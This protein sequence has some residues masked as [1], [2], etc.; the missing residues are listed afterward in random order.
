VLIVGLMIGAAAGYLVWGRHPAGARQAS[1]PGTTS[2]EV[3]RPPAEPVEAPKPYSDQAVTPPTAQPGA[4][5]QQPPAPAPREPAVRETPRPAVP[6]TGRIVV[7]SV[8]SRAGVLINGQWKGRTPLTLSAVKFGKYVVRVSQPGYMA[9]EQSFSLG[10]NDPDRT[11][12]VRLERA[13]PPPAAKPRPTPPTPPS[14]GSSTFLGSIFVDSRPQG[15]TIYIDGKARGTTPARVPEVAIGS[16]VIRLELAD[17]RAWTTSTR[18]TA[19]EET[20]VTGSLERI[21]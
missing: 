1:A 3:S 11:V 21:Q 10:A 19:G 16:H 2:S 18:V 8:P 5:V 12:S 14:S 4:T 20:R 13:T 6:V 7:Q 15:A 17:H 9:A